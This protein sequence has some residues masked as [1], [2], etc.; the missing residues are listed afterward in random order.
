MNIKCLFR[1]HLWTE[2]K[3]ISHLGEAKVRT[4]DRCGR[5]QAYSPVVLIT[6]YFGIENWINISNEETSNTTCC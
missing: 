4:C 1:F 2:E 6:N 5:K 3:I